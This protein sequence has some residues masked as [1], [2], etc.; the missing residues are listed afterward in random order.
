MDA[1]QGGDG[2]GDDGLTKYEFVAVVVAAVT[3]VMWGVALVIM[4]R[5]RISDFGAI[6]SGRHSVSVI[7][8][9]DPDFE[10]GPVRQI[11]YAEHQN[12][13]RLSAYSPGRDPQRIA[14]QKKR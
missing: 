8:P 12:P 10:R 14:V 1:T 2:D 3:A 4:R 9:A 13:G 11:A 7:G 6:S 5:N